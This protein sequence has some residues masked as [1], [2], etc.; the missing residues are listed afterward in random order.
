M[1]QR[2]LTLCQA[3][4]VPI[5]SPGFATRLS[6]ACALSGQLAE[7]LKL[8]EQMTER[9]TSRGPTFYPAFWDTLLSEACLLTGRMQEAVQLAGRALD[10]ACAHKERGHEAWALWL[11]GETVAHQAPPEIESGRTSLPAGLAL[12]DALG[13]RPSEAHCHRGLGTLYAATGQREQAAPAFSTAIEMYQSMEMTFWLP[14]T[15]VA[16]THIDG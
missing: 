14:Q 8:L 10:L 12:A 1:L 16:L 4:D 2:G 7:A 9:S 5:W 3:G 11:L 15:E 13:M 6:V